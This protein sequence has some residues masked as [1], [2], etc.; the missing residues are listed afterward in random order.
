VSLYLRLGLRFSIYHRGLLTAVFF[1]VL[2]LAAFAAALAVFSASSREAVA[3][4]VRADN[5]DKRYSLQVLN[6][7]SASRVLA[8]VEAW[9][10]VWDAEGV[11]SAS[12]RQ[13]SASVRLVRDPLPIGVLREGKFPEQDGEGTISEHLAGVLGV[14]VGDTAAVSMSGQQ[15]VVRLTGITVRPEDGSYDGV[16]VVDTNLSTI[17]ADLWLSDRRPFSD[18]MLEPLVQRGDLAARTTAILAQDRAAGFQSALLLAAEQ[19]SHVVLLLTAVVVLMLLVVVPR[20]TRR[21]VAALT[22]SGVKELWARLIPVIAALSAVLLGAIA[23]VVLVLAG[24]WVAASEV[25]ELINQE[26]TGVTVPWAAL[27]TILLA[28]VAGG[29]AGAAVSAWIRRYRPRYDDSWRSRPRFVVVMTLLGLAC[30]LLPFIDVLPVEA[31]IPGGILLTLAMPTAVVPLSSVATAPAS[32]RLV[33]TLT[34]PFAIAGALTSLLSLGTAYYSA[35][36]THAGIASVRSSPAVQPTGSYL[37][38]NVTTSAAEALHDEYL[39]LGGHRTAVYQLP[40]EDSHTLRVSGQKVVG[41][42]RASG[43]NDPLDHLSCLPKETSSPVNIVAISSALRQDEVRA[44]PGLIEGDR[45]GLI[46]FDRKTSAVKSLDVSSAVGDETLGGNMPGLVVAP[47]SE[48]AKRFG[49]RASDAALLALLDFGT[50]SE[51]SQARFRATVARLATTAQT[52]ELID[53]KVPEAT[54]GVWTATVGAAAVCLLWVSVG[55]AIS[56]SQVRQRAMYATAGARKRHRRLLAVRLMV[57]P[58]VSFLATG[59]IA[60]SAAWISGVHDGS[61]F[62]WWWVLPPVAG[63][64]AVF[65]VAW[66]HAR[67]VRQLLP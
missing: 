62:G 55:T 7:G 17:E 2:V 36:I 30:M 29:L 11:A 60:I 57:P 26:W 4:S 51:P 14:S 48:I 18:P 54:V 10:P 42:M 43:G 38:Y 12:G 63:M 21:E 50:L 23:G 31:A 32:R 13:G 46:D 8:D 61:P 3:V 5:G 6:D 64:S 24:M 1:T 15:R 19:M 28:T 33:L 47:D 53:K 67:P 41:C 27:M 25:G 65:F 20:A 35:Y 45:I 59:A 37:I 58:F 39:R 66:Q 44:D 16:V 52:S 22:D 56:T 49:L 34:T 40:V 9:H